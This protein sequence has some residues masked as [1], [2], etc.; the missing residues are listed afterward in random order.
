VAHALPNGDPVHKISIIPRGRALGYTLT[1]PTEDKF[2][3]ARSELLDELAM[4]MGGRTAEEL[5][6]ADPTTGASNDIDRAT[7]IARQMI[8]EFGMSDLLGPL[9]LGQPQ[10]EVFLGRDLTTTPD[11]SEAIAGQ[12]DAEV[13]ALVDHGH[14]V[15]REILEANRAV[16]DR[17]ADELMEHETLEVDRVQAVF[18]DVE[19]FTG[20]GL[21]RASA[22][23]ASR[24]PTPPRQTQ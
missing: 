18:A 4:L 24:R 6:F 22:A 9:R 19:L 20:S 16:L 5:V 12:I 21:G 2:L 3:V 23:A 14:A 1:L 7:T 17:L 8:T 11:Y 10:G 15:A 13:R